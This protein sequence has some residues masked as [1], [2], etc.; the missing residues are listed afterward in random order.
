MELRAARKRSGKTQE[1]VAEEANVS[2]VAYQLYEY[3]K[4]EPRV[5]TAIRIARVLG[6]T[7]ENVFRAA[8]LDEAERP[9]D[10]PA[11]RDGSAETT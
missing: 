8:T 6:N 9:G 3:D 1:Q 11:A 5:R 7:V 10:T 2:V 4:R